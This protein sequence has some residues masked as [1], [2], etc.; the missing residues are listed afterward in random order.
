MHYVPVA[1][2]VDGYGCGYT[3]AQVTEPNLMFD[4]I[5]RWWLM[6]QQIVLPCILIRRPWSKP[7]HS[8]CVRS[9]HV[10]LYLIKRYVRNMDCDLTENGNRETSHYVCA[11]NKICELFLVTHYYY[12]ES[13]G[14]M[15]SIHTQTYSNRAWT[16]D[17]R[18]P[19]LYNV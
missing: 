11:C 16:R 9:C 10:L 19:T 17:I 13:Y 18:R 7:P 4:S 15:E 2:M 8:L 1:R 6:R 14:A 12:V 3:Q 5:R